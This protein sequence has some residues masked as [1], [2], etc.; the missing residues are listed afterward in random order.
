M[1]TRFV[2]V[3]HGDIVKVNGICMPTVRLVFMQV[4]FITDIRFC[5]WLLLTVI[6]TLLRRIKMAGGVW[7]FMVVVYQELMAF[8]TTQLQDIWLISS[9]TMIAIL[10]VDNITDGVSILI[11]ALMAFIWIILKLWMSMIP[12]TLILRNTGIRFVSVQVYPAFSIL[13]RR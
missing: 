8:L 3:I 12:I 9:Y 4:F 1:W 5:R 10:I 13:T 7:N 11:F 2:M 6:F